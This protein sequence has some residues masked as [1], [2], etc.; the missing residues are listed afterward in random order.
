MFVAEPPYS[1]LVNGSPTEV[2]LGGRARR[3]DLGGGRPFVNAATGVSDIA[4]LNAWNVG[5]D[6]RPAS[7]LAGPQITNAGVPGRVYKDKGRTV[8]TYVAGDQPVAGKCRSQLSSYPVPSRRRFLFDL[9]FQVGEDAAGRGWHMTPPRESPAVLW[10]MKAPGQIPSMAIGVDTDPGAP[11]RLRLF[12]SR[13]GGHQVNPV[14]LSESVSILPNQPVRLLMDVFLDERDIPSGGRGYWRAWV[15][16]RLVVDTFGPTLSAAAKEPH[17]WYLALYLYENSNPLP[18]SRTVL[19]G[20]AR[21]LG[22]D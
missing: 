4:T 2:A 10:Q 16:G 11:D 3:F 5:H 15:N 12:F 20:Q 19:W 6:G 14:K 22:A 8:L 18:Y 7:I 17:Q 1:V 21:M 13:K 9:S